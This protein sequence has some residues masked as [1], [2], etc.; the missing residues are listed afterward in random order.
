[1]DFDDTINIIT[2]GRLPSRDDNTL[3]KILPILYIV[4]TLK[5]EGIEVF[6]FLNASSFFSCKNFLKAEFI[7]GIILIALACILYLE[8][9]R[10][11]PVSNFCYNSIVRSGIILS[12]DGL[13]TNSIHGILVLEFLPLVFRLYGIK[14]QLEEYDGILTELFLIK[15]S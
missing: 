2:M 3:R 4:L 10:N 13:I 15:N 7:L 6:L 1:M 14:S 8:Y 9:F 11:F 12:K 5:L